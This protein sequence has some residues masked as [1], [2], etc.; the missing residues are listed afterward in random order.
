MSEPSGL[1]SQPLHL[2]FSTIMSLWKFQIKVFALCQVSSNIC[3]STLLHSLQVSVQEGFFFFF[4][5]NFLIICLLSSCQGV[6]V[7]ACARMRGRAWPLQV[8]LFSPVL[9][10]PAAC[11]PPPAGRP[12]LPHADLFNCLPVP[13]PTLGVCVCVCVLLHRTTH[14]YT[15]TQEQTTVKTHKHTHTAPLLGTHKC[16]SH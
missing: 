10:L 4:N 8:L 12:E 5:S 1:R 7:R 11:L 3:C 9:L 2:D 6:C 13:G 15:Y 14:T 16:V